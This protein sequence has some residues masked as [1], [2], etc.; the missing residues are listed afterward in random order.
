LR[1]E[2]GERI[3]K[4]IPIAL[5]SAPSS[6]PSEEYSTMF[7]HNKR[8]ALLISI[9]ISVEPCTM[10]CEIQFKVTDSGSINFSEI[11]FVTMLLM[12]RTQTLER[13]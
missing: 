11:F 2:V 6:C 12:I 5:T 8:E 13:T 9:S 3:G 4:D 7:L 1:G 10:Q